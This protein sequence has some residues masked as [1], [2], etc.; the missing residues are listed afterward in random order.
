MSLQLYRLLESYSK[1][2]RTQKMKFFAEIFNSIQPLSIF[3]KN[4]ILGVR[5]TSEYAAVISSLKKII[6]FSEGG[7]SGKLFE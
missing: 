2:S 7:I 1:L 6:R 5:L 3:A 4:S